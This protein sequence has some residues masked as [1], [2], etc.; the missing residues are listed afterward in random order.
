[1]ESPYDCKVLSP[2][3]DNEILSPNTSECIQFASSRYQYDECITKLG[4][5]VDQF[6]VCNTKNSDDFMLI[7]SGVKTTL[8][9][10]FDVLLENNMRFCYGVESQYRISGLAA[11]PTVD[12]YQPNIADAFYYFTNDSYTLLPNKFPI[13]NEFLLADVVTDF[14]SDNLQSIYVIAKPKGYTLSSIIILFFIY[15]YHI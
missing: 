3:R 1:M 2:R 7:A 11:F 13:H 4:P 8:D 14:V 12:S 9:H 5:G 6:D 10:C 15:Q